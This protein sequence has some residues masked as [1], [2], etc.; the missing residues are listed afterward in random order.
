MESCSGQPTLVNGAELDYLLASRTVAP[1][2]D[3]KVSWDVPWKPHAGLVVTVDKDAPRL[4]LPQLTQYP[5]VP[6]LDEQVRAWEEFQP[7]PKPFWLGRPIGPKETQY[8]EWRHQAE[9]FV[10]QRLHEPKQGRGWYLALEHKP[11]PMSKPLNPGRKRRSCIL[12]TVL[13]FASSHCWQNG[14]W[15]RHYGSPSGKNCRSGG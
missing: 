9:Q 8:A 11:I 7:A 2:I 15:S 10:L 4:V 3:I 14:H 12:G 13:L 5:S 6:K 1:F